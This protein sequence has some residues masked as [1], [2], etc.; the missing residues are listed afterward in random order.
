MA[1]M[2]LIEI[3]MFYKISIYLYLCLCLSTTVKH[4]HYE[5]SPSW[6]HQT[7]FLNSGG[8]K[9]ARERSAGD[10]RPAVQLRDKPSPKSLLE[11]CFVSFSE[12][13]D[14][15]LGKP[16]LEQKILSGEVV[17]KVLASPHSHCPPG[18]GCPG[19]VGARPESS[20]K[21]GEIL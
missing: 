7:G 15:G 2:E 5:A 1:H 17:S 16:E 8:R 6:P 18:W 10:Y 19:A 20:C 9:V 13:S 4:S 21:P 11:I 3:S 14:T 12:N